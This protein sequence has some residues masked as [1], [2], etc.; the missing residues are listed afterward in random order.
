MLNNA[1]DFDR[2][3]IACSYTNLRQ[4]IDSLYAVIRRQL[5]IDLFLKNVLFMFCGK[6]TNK[7]KCLVREGDRFLLR[8]K[9]LLDGKY[10]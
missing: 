7:I 6:K 1:T 10:Q 2:I 5:D 9:R 4:D 3:N 8:Y